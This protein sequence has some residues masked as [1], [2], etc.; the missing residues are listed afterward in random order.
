MYGIL[1]SEYNFNV[2]MAFIGHGVKLCQAMSRYNGTIARDDN[3]IIIVVD[4]SHAFLSSF[5]QN[6]GGLF[7]V[8][9][10][11][12]NAGGLFIVLDIDKQLIRI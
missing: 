6:A 10:I 12:K 8:L 9:D 1:F 7:I 2:F 3:N 4:S 5:T 11:D